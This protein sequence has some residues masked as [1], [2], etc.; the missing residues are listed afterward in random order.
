MNWNRIAEEY[1]AVAQ[2]VCDWVEGHGG[3]ENNLLVITADHETGFLQGPPSTGS[4][5]NCPPV[6]V[7]G[8]GEMPGMVWKLGGHTNQ[9]VPLFAK[10]RK[11]DRFAELV[12]G[13]DAAHGAYVDNTDIA[14]VLF[15]AI[16]EP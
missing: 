15:E 6:A 9:L 4:N 12:W 13:Q 11:A 5:S 3:W 14:R 7:R 16:R 8:K 1:L 2:E 10:G